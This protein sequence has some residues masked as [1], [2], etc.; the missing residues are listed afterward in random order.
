M[1][2]PA[3]AAA[4]SSDRRELPT[5]GAERPGTAL[6]S[7]FSPAGSSAEP[8]AS[9]MSSAQQPATP[10]QLKISSMRDVERWLAEE[11]IASCDSVDMHDIREAAAVLSC[12]NPRKED[13]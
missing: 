3:S 11:S 1:K 9:A 6:R 8:P 13:V 10:C 4:S 12:P 2:R 7:F 5:S